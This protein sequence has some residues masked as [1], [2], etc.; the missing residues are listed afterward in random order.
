MFQA[1]K[2]VICLSLAVYV[3]AQGD[4]FEVCV[5]LADGELVGVGNDVSCTGYFYC[6]GEYG[7]EEDCVE[8]Y[9]AEFEFNYETNLCD[10]NDVVQCAPL[11]EPEPDPDPEPEPTETVPPIT[12]TPGTT[13]S[14]VT[15]VTTVPDIECPTNRPGEIL[16]FESSNCTEYFICANGNRIKM[17]CMEGFTWNQDDKQC[18][19]PIFSRCSVIFGSTF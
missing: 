12:Q 19:Y 14:T 16:F 9:G 11:P 6:E 18:D 3:K 8:Q 4:P 5:G 17:Q 2:L 15:S 13:T 1:L 7:Y 10:Y